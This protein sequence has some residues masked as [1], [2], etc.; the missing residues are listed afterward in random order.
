[1]AKTIA[2]ELKKTLECLKQVATYPVS[3]EISEILAGFNSLFFDVD[4][5]K[6][7]ATTDPVISEYATANQAA[8]H[9][10]EVDGTVIK[11]NY[12]SDDCIAFTSTNETQALLGNKKWF[13]LLI[14]VGQDATGVSYSGGALT[15]DDVTEAGTVG[16]DGEKEFVLYVYEGQS[17][18][19]YLEA[20]GKQKTTYTIYFNN[21][22]A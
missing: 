15:A 9:S 19:F 11:I 13:G 7:N 10:I 14:N 22:D 6:S 1:M 2:Q 20:T 18:T 17:K 4:C 12:H 3:G 21:L 16:G 8:I 5:K